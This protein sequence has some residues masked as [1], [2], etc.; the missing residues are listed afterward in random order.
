MSETIKL[1]LQTSHDI[2]AQPGVWSREMTKTPWHDSCECSATVLR[3]AMKNLGIGTGLL[4]E[5]IQ[6]NDDDYLT[7]LND[8][9]YLTSLNDDDYL[10]SLRALIEQLPEEY[11]GDVKDYTDSSILWKWNDHRDRTLEEVLT[12][13]KAAIA[14]QSGEPTAAE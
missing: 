10:T 5:G 1:I 9:D 14:A 3:R 6:P 11:R 7:S 2:L 13:F 12:V 4:S 8:D